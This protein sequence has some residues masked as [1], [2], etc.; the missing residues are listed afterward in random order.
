MSVSHLFMQYKTEA[1]YKRALY[2]AYN[3]TFHF[4]SHGGAHAAAQTENMQKMIIS[5]ILF[6]KP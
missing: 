6:F 5:N 1:Q 4:R 2:K 3:T